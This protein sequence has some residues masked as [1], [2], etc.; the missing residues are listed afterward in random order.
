VSLR[1]GRAR[2]AGHERILRVASKPVAVV[3]LR[4]LHHRQGHGYARRGHRDNA[5]LAVSSVS[6]CKRPSERTTAFGE[7]EIGLDRP[8]LG[9]LAALPYPSPCWVHSKMPKGRSAL[10]LENKQLAPAGPNRYYKT[11]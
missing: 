5:V 2:N 6:E 7:S 10:R 3:R 1:L 9:R 4:D 8:R 11:L